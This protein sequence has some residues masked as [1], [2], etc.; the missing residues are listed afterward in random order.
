[1]KFDFT[2]IIIKKKNLNLNRWLDI[3]SI[4]FK[5]FSKTMQM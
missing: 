1:M 5:I 3:L 2:E 4:I